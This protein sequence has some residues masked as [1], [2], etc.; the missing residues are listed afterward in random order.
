MTD[1]SQKDYKKII[2]R[3]DPRYDGRFYFGVKTTHIYCRPVCPARPKP[4]NIVIFKSASQAE[5]AGY[6]PCKRCHPDLAPGSKLLEGTTVSVGRA[7]RLIDEAITASSD[8]ELSVQTLAEKL[9]MSDRHL[10]RLFEEHLG[11]SP[12][13]IITT[14]KLHF[15]RLLVM[16]TQG[17]LAD[18]AL[19]AGFKSVRRFN[20]AFKEFYNLA[21]SELRKEHAEKI[22]KDQII[23]HLSIR[24]PYDWASI[25]AFLGRHETYGLEEVHPDYFLRYIPHGKGYGTLKV[26]YEPRKSALKLELTNIHLLMVRP[27]ISSLKSLFDT[28]HNPNDLPKSK[29]VHANGIRIPGAFDNYE[30]AVSIILGQLVSTVLAKAK[31]KDLVLKYGKKISKKSEAKDVY[32]FP[33]PALLKDAKLEELGMTRHKANAIRELSRLVESKEIVISKTADLEETRK[34]LLAIKG[35]GPWT[36]EMIAMRC[37]GDTNAYPKKDLII[38]RAIESGLVDEDEWSSS[39]AYL[40]HILWREYGKSLSK[41]GSK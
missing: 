30:T 5:K 23:L 28:E 14:K 35:I 39:K 25:M 34:K 22:P 6:R 33:S 20:E 3:R 4:E 17:P 11:A 10:R 1:L 2:Q 32:I 40:T 24:A 41:T 19:A 12:I 16:E 38:A 26:S 15:A 31:M 37:M 21:P 36:V 29:K 7:L 27:L 13:E 8:E 18:I 9:G